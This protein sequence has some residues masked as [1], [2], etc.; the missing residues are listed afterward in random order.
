MSIAKSPSSSGDNRK[1]PDTGR[2]SFIWKAGAA[3]SAVVASAATGFSKS[4]VERTDILQDANAVRTL[5][6]AYE[7]RLHEGR[8]EEVLDLFDGKA[9]VV[10]NGGLFKDQKGLRR[11]YCDLFR[12]GMTG[13]KIEPAPGFEPDAEQQLDIVEI[14]PDRKSATGRFPFS[15]Q[16]G[17]PMQSGSSLVD[18]ARLQGEGIRKWWEGGTYKVTYVKTGSGWKIRRL[19]YRAASKADYRPGRSHAKAIDI[20]T[21]AT[22]YPADPAGPDKLV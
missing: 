6:R 8:Y 1:Q 15:I 5:H 14:S 7:A 10:Y 4:G 20:P 3:M 18:M 11:L 2:R 22:T 17:K 13:K 12:S 19:E 16:A 21:F 9:E